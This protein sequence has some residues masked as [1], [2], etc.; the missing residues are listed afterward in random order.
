VTEPLTR[1]EAISSNWISSN[2]EIA[3]DVD[4]DVAIDLIYGP[5][6]YRLLFRH[7]PIDPGFAEAIVRRAL[8]GLAAGVSAVR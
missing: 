7:L 8:H 3:A 4:P 2:G 6:Y 5:L 1:V